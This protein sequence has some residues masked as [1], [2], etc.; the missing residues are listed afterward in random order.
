MYR[1]N[2]LSRLLSRDRSC[3]PD[4]VFNGPDAL[5]HLTPASEAPAAAVKTAWEP[6]RTGQ[7]IPMLGERVSDDVPCDPR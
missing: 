6:V 3:P 7:A 5:A 1:R 4:Q 2:T